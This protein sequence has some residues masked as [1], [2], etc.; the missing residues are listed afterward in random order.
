MPRVGDSMFELSGSEDILVALSHWSLRNHKMS[1]TRYPFEI[2]PQPGYFGLLGGF[3]GLGLYLLLAVAF[4]TAIVGFDPT[5]ALSFLSFPLV[6]GLAMIS[7]LLL[8]YS[9]AIISFTIILVV[10]LLL[11]RSDA[12]IFEKMSADQELSFVLGNAFTMGLFSTISALAF[13]YDFRLSELA[14]NRQNLLHKIFDALPIGIWVRARDGRSIFVNDRWAEFSSDSADEI[15]DSGR[16]E[17]PVDLGSDWDQLLAGIIDSDDSAVHYKNIELENAKGERTNMT[18]LTLRMFIDQEDDFGSLSLLIDETALRAYEVKIRQSEQNLQT[19]LHNAKMG[20]WRE[21]V[22]TSELHCD[23]NWYR[24]LEAHSEQNEAPVDVWNRRLHPEDRDRLHR[25]YR[26]FYASGGETTRL[27]Y[28]I[29]KGEKKYIWVQDSA[30]VVERADDG[31]ARC[32]IGTMQ[33]ISER[34]EDEL[35]LKLAKEK[36]ETANRVKGQ[37]IATI[38]HEIRTPLNAIIGLSSF[39]AEGELNEDNLDLAQTIHSSGK[40]LLTLVN[41]ILDFSKIESGRLRLEMQEFPL[42]LC[43]EESV[44]LFKLPATEKNLR[45]ELKIDE[46]LPEYAFGDMDRLR[47]ILQNLLANALKFTDEGEVTLSARPVSLADFNLRCGANSDRLELLEG[48]PDEKL[49]EVSIKDSGIGIPKERQHL[50]FQ[51]FSQLDASTTRKYE[52]TGLGLVIC[53]RLVH[54][55]GGRIWLESEDGAGAEFFFVVPIKLVSDEQYLPS[56]RHPVVQVDRGIEEKLAV[57]LPLNVLVVG[58]EDS[59]AGL[60]KSFRRLGYAPHH[61]EDYD[62]CRSASGDRE[63]DLLLIVLDEESRALELARSVSKSSYAMRPEAIIGILPAGQEV[64]IDQC[65]LAGFLRVL[66]SAPTEEELE[67]VIRQAVDVRD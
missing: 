28:C 20:F 4:V 29:R 58:P 13:G 45:L 57:R 17:P 63:Y 31:S 43:L 26:E 49:L 44:K 8:R 25:S 56:S 12:G 16:T 54:A 2:E 21:N 19:A 50:L 41:E 64:S 60:L 32:I 66:Q 48:E 18:L 46:A 15:V 7:G 59:T 30:L 33:D 36:A 5:E 10:G 39:L 27:D 67:A 53:K 9:G 55:M 34:K 42:V 24:L 52:G 61:L 3:K 37:F 40:N 1:Y 62:L 35:E 47:Q 51:A 6:L 65:R 11:M 22:K 23:D 38:S 14:T